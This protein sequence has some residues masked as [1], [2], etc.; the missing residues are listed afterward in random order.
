MVRTRGRCGNGVGGTG[1]CPPCH[2]GWSRWPAL[3]QDL[4]ESPPALTLDPG[5]EL[6]ESSPG[7]R[8]HSLV[9]LGDPPHGED[10]A[11]AEWKA[12]GQSRL[13]KPG[14][15]HLGILMEPK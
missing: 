3:L 9:V 11:P 10:A 7:P 5:V 8:C 12:R 1:P 13:S 14:H 4:G 15:R 2:G 6:G